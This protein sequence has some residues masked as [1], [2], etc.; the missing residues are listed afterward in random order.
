VRMPTV[1]VV[2]VVIF[3]VLFHPFWNDVWMKGTA[4]ITFRQ[5]LFPPTVG[6]LGIVAFVL[7]HEQIFHPCRLLY[8]DLMLLEQSLDPGHVVLFFKELIQP[9]LK[10]LCQVKRLKTTAHTAHTN[11]DMMVMVMVVMV[12]VLHACR[13]V[14]N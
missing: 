4:D 6:V 1:M 8:C 13:L 14:Y 12:R 2:F 5:M 9:W 11:T 7:V 3:A 10:F